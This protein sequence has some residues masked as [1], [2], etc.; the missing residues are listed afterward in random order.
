M[1][2]QQHLATDASTPHIGPHEDHR[3]VTA[4]ADDRTHAVM[5]ATRLSQR[6]STSPDRILDQN[7]DGV[8]R[9]MIVVS[10]PWK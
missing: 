8:M 5:S 3:H 7:H 6:H 4:L 1:Q 9:Y 10:L 2:F